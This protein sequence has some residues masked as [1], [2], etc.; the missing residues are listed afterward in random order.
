MENKVVRQIGCED[1]R[2]SVD[3]QDQRR[4]IQTENLGGIHR[5]QWR[6]RRRSNRR[7]S[8][9]QYRLW[10]AERRRIIEPQIVLILFGQ[11]KRGDV[12]VLSRLRCT[13]IADPIYRTPHKRP[14]YASP[15]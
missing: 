12:L 1:Q 5:P 4:L 8:D 15:P 7:Q 2:S 6:Q 13:E 9:H 11:R 14:P 3:W 10:I